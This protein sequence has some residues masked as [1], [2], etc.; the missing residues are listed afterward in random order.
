MRHSVLMGYIYI[1]HLLRYSADNKW[2]GVII[3][4][5]LV[6]EVDFKMSNPSMND[7]AKNV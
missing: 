4:T 5:F 7:Q 3:C 1:A 6:V 2:F